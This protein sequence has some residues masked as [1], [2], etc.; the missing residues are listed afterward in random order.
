MIALSNH[1]IDIAI[2]HTL[3]DL[4]STVRKIVVTYLTAFKIRFLNLYYNFV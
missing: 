3:L 1:V 4:Y 2:S